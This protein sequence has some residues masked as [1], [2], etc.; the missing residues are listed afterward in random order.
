MA[1]RKR[2]IDPHFRRAALA[3][4]RSANAV[5]AERTPPGLTGSRLLDCSSILV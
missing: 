3:G 5:L 1:V 2:R 4:A